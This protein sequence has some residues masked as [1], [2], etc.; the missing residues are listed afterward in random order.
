MSHSHYPEEIASKRKGESRNAQPFKAK[1][2]SFSGKMN[3]SQTKITKFFLNCSN[4]HQL[5]LM[6]IQELSKACNVSNSSVTRFIQALGYRTFKEFQIAVASS[7]SSVSPVE[8]AY[9]IS[10]EG[11]DDETL[12]KNVFQ[13]NLLSIQNT[14]KLVHSETISQVV[15]AILN[16][17][18]VFIVASGRSHIVGSYFEQ[19]LLRIGVFSH[20]ICDPHQ[21]LNIAVLSSPG[22]LVIGISESGRSRSVVNSLSLARERGIQCVSLTNTVDSPLSKASDL[23]VYSAPVQNHSIPSFSLEPSTST[24]PL[25]VIV[26]SIYVLL[27]LRNAG[28]SAKLITESSALLDELEK[29][30]E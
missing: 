26:D 19:R 12:V 28:H 29:L 5:S 4:L 6:T 14:M 2:T 23:V 21:Q 27:Y 10:V 16:A 25:F 24:I 11:N 7:I 13:M 22:D 20:A 8:L 30:E 3:E 15:D 18:N 17:N 9:G 1:I